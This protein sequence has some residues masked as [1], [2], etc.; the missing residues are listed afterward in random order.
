M[1]KLILILLLVITTKISSQVLTL[2][3]NTVQRWDSI[4]H[5]YSEPIEHYVTS[6]VYIDS[7][8]YQLRD[9]KT[10]KVLTLQIDSYKIGETDMILICRGDLGRLWELYITDT[11][12]HHVLKIKR[13]KL[14]MLYKQP[15]K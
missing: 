1:K 7:L 4:E 8:V 2:D 14:I 12:E 6:I 10:G 13:G 11:K 3:Y 9:N 5:R 15:L